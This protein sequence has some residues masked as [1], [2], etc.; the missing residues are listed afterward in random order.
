MHAC[1]C[2]C[3]VCVCSAPLHSARLFTARP[4]PCGHWRWNPVVSRESKLGAWHGQEVVVSRLNRRP[5]ASNGSRAEFPLTTV[6]SGTTNPVVVSR[7]SGSTYDMGEGKKGKA[8]S[9][10]E[11]CGISASLGANLITSKGGP[12]SNTVGP[13]VDFQ[14]TLVQSGTTNPVVVPKAS[15]SFFDMDGGITGKAR[16]T[17]ESCG[18]P[19]RFIPLQME[20]AQQLQR[21]C[22]NT[23]TGQKGKKGYG[24]C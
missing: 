6:Q 8:C 1:C 7:A 16:S 15:R 17:V 21:D 24:L 11:S 2:C 20:L 10:V 19:A 14:F 5:F 3:D 18:I 22:V 23:T 12:F 4:H 13:R 9:T